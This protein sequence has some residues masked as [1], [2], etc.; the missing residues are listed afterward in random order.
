M[1]EVEGGVYKATEICIQAFAFYEGLI[2]SF[3]YKP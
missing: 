3:N 2:D 1:G